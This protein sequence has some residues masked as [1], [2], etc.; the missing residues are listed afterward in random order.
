MR[1]LRL[2]LL[3]A[4]RLQSASGEPVLFPTKKSKAMLA[5]LALG[6][7]H[8]HARA[9]LADLLWEDAC[10]RRSACCGARCFLPMGSR[11]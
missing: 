8:P 3:G 9:Q 11:S 7:E 6:G 1:K 4:F 5:Y 2:Q 10:A